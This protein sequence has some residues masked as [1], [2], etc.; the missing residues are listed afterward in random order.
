MPAWT[1]GRWLRLSILWFALSLIWSALLS[2][3][4]PRQVDTFAPP[5]LRGTFLG[6]VLALGGLG[7]AATQIL[8][9]Y[10]SDRSRNPWG[11]RR[12]YIVIGVS[13]GSLGLLFLA[14]AQGPWQMLAAFIWLQLTLNVAN[15]PYQALMPD[16]W[17][18]ATSTAWPQPGWDSSSTS[19]RPSARPW[20]ATSCCNREASRSWP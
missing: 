1:V 10:R 8:A 6:L 19:A 20:P 13:L 18:P 15:G 12:P 9:G 5:E 16:S 3:V 14:L 17:C 2:I 11:K 4:V 7:A